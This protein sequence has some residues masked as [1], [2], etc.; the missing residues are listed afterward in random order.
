[1][2]MPH[3]MEFLVSNRM[4]TKILSN[5]YQ[6]IIKSVNNC[7][8][9]ISLKK[10]LKEL[11]N[12]K[13]SLP[14]EIMKNIYVLKKFGMLMSN[15]V[16]K[17]HNPLPHFLQLKTIKAIL[18]YGNHKTNIGKLKEVLYIFKVLTIQTMI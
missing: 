5:N 6:I 7:S 16:I 18:V 13:T 3:S 14:S 1:M 8:P 15:K 12:S 9:S 17:L 2:K 11:I 4:L 10:K